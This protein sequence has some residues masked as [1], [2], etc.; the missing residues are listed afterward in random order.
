MDT[1]VTASK[2]F[3]A[4]LDAARDALSHS[5]PGAAAEEILEA[6]LDLLL[7]RAAR[8]RG[9]VKKPRA[10]SPGAANVGSSANPR[11]VP[12]EV[13]REVLLRDDGRCQWRTADGGIC[14]STHRVQL[15]HVLPVAQGGR[16]T[17]ANLR[18]LCGFHNDL[19]ARAAFGDAWMDKFTR[20]TNRPASPT[21]RAR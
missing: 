11:H 4:K 12:A 20:K 7:D 2:R 10:Q 1:D 5:H 6:G 17:V 3:L 9:L 21:S 13:S 15:D 19:A 8:R 14:G 16:S 18:V